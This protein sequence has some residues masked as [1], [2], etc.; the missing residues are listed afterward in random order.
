MVEALTS[1]LAAAGA[2]ATKSREGENE[3]APIVSMSL[4]QKGG[5]DVVTSVEQVVVAA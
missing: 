3:Q 4:Q 2:E 5:C 1:S